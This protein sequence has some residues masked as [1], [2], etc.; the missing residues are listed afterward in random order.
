[1]CCLNCQKDTDN[2]YCSVEC[3]NQHY[4][5]LHLE[6][7]RKLQQV[8]RS[9]NKQPITATCHTCNK[10]FESSRKISKDCSGECYNKRRSNIRDNLSDEA[11]VREQ[12][13][14]R[15]RYKRMREDISRKL[16]VDLRCRL[17]R[18][19]KGNYKA[20]SA[21]RDLGCS[22]EEF[23]AHL[24][25]QFLPGMSWNNHTIG[26]WHIDHIEP[27]SKFNLSDIEELKQA[28]HYS[29]LQPLWAKDNLKKGD[30]V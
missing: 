16:K 17:N 2:K 4:R 8:W 13:L 7:R 3:N 18:A 22:V 14:S 1:M 10:E 27:L 12:N 19:L 6:H 21:V 20:G 11:I 25:S 28:C 24:E 29:N 5:F 9:K 26:G 23:K 30:K 15:A